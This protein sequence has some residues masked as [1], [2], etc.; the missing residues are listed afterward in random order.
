[1]CHDIKKKILVWQLYRVVSTS[2][3]SRPIN[4]WLSDLFFVISKFEHSKRSSSEW[5]PSRME[6]WKEVVWLIL[7]GRN[8][9]GRLG[10]RKCLCWLWSLQIRVKICLVL[11]TTDFAFQNLF[12]RSS[13]FFVLKLLFIFHLQ[14]RRRR[15][16]TLMSK[17]LMTVSSER[18]LMK[19]VKLGDF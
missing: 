5:K 12:K 15:K 9:N 18:D 10:F 1:M 13:N 2:N 17:I 11:S 14:R 7:E 4:R 6:Q 8:C 3:C 16:K 19:I